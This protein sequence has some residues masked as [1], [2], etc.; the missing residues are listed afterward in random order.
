MVEGACTRNIQPPLAGIRKYAEYFPRICRISPDLYNS[1]SV[2]AFKGG[3]IFYCTSE[4][5]EKRKVAYPFARFLLFCNLSLDIREISVGNLVFATRYKHA[6]AR[7]VH[8]VDRSLQSFI[9]CL[10]VSVYL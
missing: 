6:R 4:P 5:R 10:C 9:I 1:T 2:I 7:Q 8:H 3:A